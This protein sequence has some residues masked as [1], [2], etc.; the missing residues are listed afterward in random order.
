MRWRVA[1]RRVLVVGL[2]VSGTSA[3]RALKALG[4]Q[5]RVTEKS[6]GDEV[7][8]RAASLEEEG[9]ETETGGHQ[10]DRLETDIAVIS[11]GIPP[12]AP[13]IQAL[14]CAG[15]ELIS[16]VELAYRAAS[17]SLTSR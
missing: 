17:C 16:E 14:R 15:I 7:R 8:A 11:P 5:V 1:G 10:L 6:S 4:A 2:G 3:A 13:V 9:I 12:T